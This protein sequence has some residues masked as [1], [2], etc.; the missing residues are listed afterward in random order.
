ML[1]K[2]YVWSLPSTEKVI[3]LTFDD[4]PIPDVTEFVLDQLNLFNAKATF[5]CVGENIKKHP[6]IFKKIVENGHSYGNHTYNHIKG[7]SHSDEYYFENIAKFENELKL[8]NYQPSTIFR[9]PYGRIKNSQ[10]KILLKKYKIIMWNLLTCDYDKNLKPELCLK[11][12]IKNTKSGAIIVF[13]DSLKAEHNLRYV[14]P[15]YL[16]YLK[17]EGYNFKTIS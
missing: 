15:L 7:W 4:G 1:F 6:S 17:K 5:F 12:T 14:L 10:G 11:N 8:Q 3:Y 9:P 2:Q 13:H 16:E